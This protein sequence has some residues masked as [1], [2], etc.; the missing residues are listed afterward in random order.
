MSHCRT[1]LQYVNL[2][3]EILRIHLQTLVQNIWRIK[4]TALGL[5][6]KVYAFDSE[7]CILE[8]ITFVS[9]ATC[10]HQCLASRVKICNCMRL[11]VL[12]CSS[13]DCDKS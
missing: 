8:T 6:A 10:L 3:F 7:S 5:P 11:I 4:M 12:Q 13:F 2:P 9:L 1:V